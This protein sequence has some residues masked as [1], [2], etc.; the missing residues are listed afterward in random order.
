MPGPTSNTE[1]KLPRGLVM[2]GPTSNTELKLSRGLVMPGPT[3]NT[4][5]ITLFFFKYEL[6]KKKQ[7]V[8]QLA[9]NWYYKIV[10]KNLAD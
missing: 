5:H 3:S 4:R 8:I 7:Y 2:P 6:F 1:L 10:A 9:N